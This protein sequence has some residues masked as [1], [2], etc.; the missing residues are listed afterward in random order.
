MKNRAIEQRIC[1]NS[2]S[3]GAQKPMV[4]CLHLADGF[5]E[6]TI[7]TFLQGNLS[8]HFVISKQGEITQMVD[9][10]RVA[11]TQGI[12]A[13]QTKQSKA[14]LVRE[15]GINPNSYCLSVEFEGFYNDFKRSNGEVIKGCKGNITAEQ[16]DSFVFLFYYYN[17]KYQIPIDR[18]HIIG[19]CE[20]NHWGRPHCP[21]ELFPYDEIMRK[22]KEKIPTN[23]ELQDKIYKV[24]LGAFKEQ[25]NAVD[26]KNQ[27]QEKGYDAI[28]I[29]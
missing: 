29:S 9:T 2:A 16:I 23:P 27:L 17:E 28:V 21:G 4:W 1:K 22:L 14:K 6:G 10:D 19:H 3:R 8:A 24:Q 15:K 20:I 18:E 12:T 25:K 5:Y 26:F 11:F 7:Q 13:E